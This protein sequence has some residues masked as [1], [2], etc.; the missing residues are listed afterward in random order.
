MQTIARV[1]RPMACATSVDAE[2]AKK[3]D[4]LERGIGSQ[5]MFR[6]KC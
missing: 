5:Q 2:D 6:P 4:N 3:F 1:G